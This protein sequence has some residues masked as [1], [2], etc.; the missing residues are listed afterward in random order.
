LFISCVGFE[1]LTQLIVK[2]TIFWNV[3]S[4]SLQR[5]TD[6]SEEPTAYVIVG[7]STVEEYAKKTTASRAVL[8]HE[9]GGSIFL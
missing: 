7:R 9:N 5:F 6:V 8:H 2:F 4:C 1:V 3:T